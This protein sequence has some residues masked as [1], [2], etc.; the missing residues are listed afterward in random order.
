MEHKT[1]L[2]EQFDG[3]WITLEATPSGYLLTW[4]DY[5]ANDWVQ[6]FRTLSEAFT[7]V[8]LCLADAQDGNRELI[9]KTLN[10]YGGTN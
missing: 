9:T 5:V 10:N 6:G 2:D 4:G 1:I 8:A 3:V 7:V